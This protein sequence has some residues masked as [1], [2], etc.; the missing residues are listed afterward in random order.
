[1]RL[2]VPDKYCHHIPERAINVNGTTCMWDVPG[3]TDRTVLTNRPDTVLYDRKEKT[4]LLIDIATPID[5]NVNTNETEQLNKCKDLENEASRMWKVRTKIVL[6]TV[7]ALGTV[8]GLDQNRQSLSA[9]PSATE[10]LTT[11]M[12]TAHC[13]CKVLG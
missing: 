12:S 8:Q 5:S 7:G 1:M 13:I 3:V 10:L 11:L 6:V 9:Q 4:C 2:Q